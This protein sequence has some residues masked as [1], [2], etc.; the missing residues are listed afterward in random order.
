MGE[1]GDYAARAIEKWRGSGVEGGV[2][3]DCNLLKLGSEC[4]QRAG[5]VNNCQDSPLGLT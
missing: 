3:G 2:G 4:A 5:C 1:H